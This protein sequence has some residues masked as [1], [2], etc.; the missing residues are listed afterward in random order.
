MTPR[1]SPADALYRLIHGDCLDVMRTMD[2]ASVDAV[3]TDPPYGISVDGAVSS[4]PMGSRNMDF[5]KNDTR[6]APIEPLR[7]AIRLLKRPGSFFAFCGHGQFGAIVA[8]L[9]SAGMETKPF[10]WVKSC[11][12]PAAPGMRWTSGFELA[13]YAFDYGS[14]FRP[15]GAGLRPNVYVGDS[16]RHGQPGKVAHPTQKP[17]ALM[18]EIVGRLA[19]P[20]AVVLDPFTGSGS[21]GVAAIEEGCSFVGIEREAEYVAI[22][23]ARLKHASCAPLLPFDDR[24][25]KAIAAQLEFDMG[26]DRESAEAVVRATLAKGEK[27]VD[28]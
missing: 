22:A 8:I 21:T 25:T 9:E 3:V 7:E 23:E 4:G 24:A 20:G 2:A 28:V 14:Y 18:R 17:I 11:P 16:Y 27:S 26:T 19:R 5:F 15:D 12:V 1:P 6:E 13:V 10:A